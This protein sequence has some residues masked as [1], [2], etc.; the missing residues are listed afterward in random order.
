VNI[1]ERLRAASKAL[2]DS[3]VAQ[4]D[5]ATRL[6]EIVRRTGQPVAHGHTA[7][8]GDEPQESPRSLALSLPASGTVSAAPEH[9]VA[10]TP[11]SHWTDGETRSTFQSQSPSGNAVGRLLG[12]S[13]RYKPLIAVAA[14]LGALLGYG[15]AARQPTL[16]E[17][18]SQVLLTGTPSISLSDDAPPSRSATPSDTS[19]TRPPSSARPPSWSS[20]RRR[21]GARQL[22]RTCAPPWSSRS[23]RTPIN[24]PS[25][26]WTGMRTGRRC[27][28]TR[29]PRATRASSKDDLA[30]WRT[31]C[32]ASARN[33]RRGSRP[34]WTRS[35]RSWPPRRTTPACNDDAMPSTM[36]S[37]GSRRPWSGWRPASGPIS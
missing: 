8:L 1:D 26:F 6:R 25:A 31:S 33:S 18:A 32:A 5:A 28:P 11:T 36:S 23:T 24:S 29:S 35:M 3:S 34:G 16:Y 4:V 37:S 20:R 2:R 30:S 17:A 9:S 19:G 7:V 13:W 10:A 22:S 15:W 27:S 21:A 14:L 12:S